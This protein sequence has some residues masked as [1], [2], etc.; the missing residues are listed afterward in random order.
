MKKTRNKLLSWLLVLA[1]LMTMLPTVVL[2]LS[3]DVYIGGVNL[4]DGSKV[5]YYVNGAATAV[6]QEPE[7]WNA[8]LETVGGVATLTIR[9][10]F[11]AASG[12]EGIKS[13]LPLNLVLEG[14]NSVTGGDEDSSWPAYG[15][16]VNGD[17]TISGDGSLSVI[18]VASAED[19]SYGIYAYGQIEINGGTVSAVGGTASGSSYGIYSFSGYGIV[20]NDGTVNATGGTATE[21]SYGICA[22]SRLWIYGGVVNATG[23]T[24]G[25]AEGN[26]SCGIS[27]WEGALISGG[28]VNATGGAAYLSYGIE[29]CYE[30][31]GGTV[32]ATGGDA[33]IYSFG[34]TRGTSST[35]FTGGVVVMRG[36]TV[37]DPSGSANA[38]GYDSIELD[39][40]KIAGQMVGSNFAGSTEDYNEDATAVVL[41][42]DDYTVRNTPLTGTNQTEYTIDTNTAVV[43]PGTSENGSPLIITSSDS[44]VTLNSNLVLINLLG[45]FVAPALGINGDVTVGGSGVLTAIGAVT[46]NN[47]SYG[48][49]GNYSLS[50]ASAQIV[51]IGGVSAKYSYGIGA[52]T[53]VTVSGDSSVVAIGGAMMNDD[54]DSY[55]IGSYG[56]SVSDTSEI[57]AIGGDVGNSAFSYGISTYGATVSGTAKVTAVGGNGGSM[58]ASYGV[59]CP[60][61]ADV[62]VTVSGGTLNAVAGKTGGNSYGINNTAGTITVGNS[63]TGGTVNAVGGPAASFSAG[64][65]GGTV[66]VRRGSLNAVGGFTDYVGYGIRLSTALNVSGGTVNAAGMD[67]GI[68]GQYGQGVTISGGDV[69]AVG[70]NSFGL[71]ASSV[72]SLAAGSFTGGMKAVYC[73]DGVSSLL[74]NG[75]GYFAGDELLEVGDADT[76]GNPGQTV[77]VKS[78]VRE[79]TV[80]FNANGGSGTMNNQ[81]IDFGV[82]TVLSQNSFTKTDYIFTGWNTKADGSGTSYTDKATVTGIANAGESITLYAMWGEKV[83]FEVSDTKHIYQS[84]KGQSITLTP[85]SISGVLTADD[86][87]V[88]YYK[89][90]ENENKLVS[91]AAVTNA[92]ETGKYL[93]VI[94][95]TTGT[96]YSNYAIEK[97]FTVSDTTLPDISE[98]SNIGYMY[99]KTGITGQQ[100][101][102]FFKDGTVN[103]KVGGEF[104][105]ELTNDNGTTP[106]FTS[107]NE[108]VA[109]VDSTGKVTAI[110]KGTATI[111]A[112]SE[113]DETTP[114]YASYTVNVGFATKTLTAND[115]TVTA[116]NKTY[117]GTKDVVISATVKSEALYAGDNIRVDITGEF[118][119]GN[120]GENKTVNYKITGIS[121]T[122]AENYVL[123][124]GII[125][126]TTT[127]SITKA[128]VTIICATATTRIFDGTP[129]SVDVSAMANGAVFDSSNYTVKYNGGEAPSAVGSYLVTVE[130]TA[131]AEQNYTVTQPNAILVIG[132][133]SQEV[134]SVEGVPEAVYYGDNFTLSTEGASGTV[135]YAITSGTEFAEINGADVTVTGVGKVTI[136]ATSVKNGYAD[137]IAT[138]SFNAKQRILIPTATA[139]DK[140]Y[141]GTNGV[142]VAIS[143]KNIVDSDDIT[144]TA[145]GS[146]INADAGND[147]L[148]YVSGIT[149]DGDKKDFYTLDTTSIQTTVDIS[150]KEITG[151][152]IS[153]DSRKYDT[154]SNA[155]ATVTGISGVLEADKGQVEVIG[156]AAFDDENSGTGKT[157]TFTANGL[158]GAKAA[159]YTLT[160]TTA[161]ATADITPLS[162]DFVVGNTAFV[163]DGNDKA[164][165][166]SATDENGKIFKD[167]E[168]TYN[169]TPNA[170]GTYTAT[171]VLNDT[172]NYTTE[173]DDVSVTIS[174]AAQ[175]NLVI[176]G[177]PG[178]IQYGDSFT[179]EAVGGADGGA[180]EWNVDNADVTLSTN[181]E[182]ETTVTIGDVVGEKV[183]IEVVKKTDNYEDISAKV[184]FVPTAKAVTFDISNLEQ[185]YGN[186]SDVEVTPSDTKVSEDDYTIT[187]NGGELPENAGTYTV[188][189]AANGNYSGMQTATLT[190]K[191]ATATGTITG[192]NDSYTYGDIIT[193]VGVTDLK[194]STAAK[195]TYAGTGIYV[196]Q[197]EAPTK[198]GNYTVIAEIT[199]D[200][201]ETLT[202][203]ENFV[204]E[205]KELTVKA[206]DETRAYGE[207]NPIFT[208]SYTGFVNGETKDVLLAEPIAT[209]TANA[210]SGVGEYDITVSGGS[211]ENYK[212]SYDNTGKLTV[213]GATGGSLYITGSTNTAYVNDIFVL[214]AFY[215]NSK[216]NVTWESSDSTIAEIAESGTVT[217]KKAGTVTIKATA[218][219]NYGNAT[220]TFELTVKQT[221]ITLVPTD[222]VKIYTGER[223][224]ITFAH[225]A[226]F[227]PVLSG[228]DK[229]VDVTYTLISNPSVTEPI[230]AGTYSVVYTISDGRYT[231][232]GNTTMYIN[233]AEI[234]VKPKNITKVYGDEPVY[235]LE[236]EST[237]I[238]ANEL[239]TLAENTTFT[240]EGESKIAAVKD[241]G[242][243]IT[244]TLNTTENENLKF[245][246]N[247]TGT[248]TVAKA[249]LTVKVKDITREYG[250]ENPTLEAEY[251]GFKNEETEKTENIFTGNLTL[252]YDASINA[253]TAVGEYADK[254]TAAGIEAANYGITFV[255]GNVKITKIGVIASAGTS[256]SSYLTVKFDKAIA[257]LGV[258]N[259]DVKNG[260]ET[261][262]ITEVTA[263]SDNKT[264]TLKGSF[265]TSVTYTV[266]PN[267]TGST[268]E[269]THEITSEPLSIKPSS[270]GGGGGGGG[271]SAPTTYTVKFETDGGSEIDSVK[272]TKNKTIDEP[273]APTKDD[274]TFDGWYTDEALTEKYDFDSKVT[275]N[276]TLYAKWDKHD[277]EQPGTDTHNC[278][279][280]AFDD[281]DITK[282]YHFDTD[283]VIENG[284]FKGTT[285]TTFEPDSAQTRAMM[286]TV[287]YRAEGEPAVNRSIPFADVDKGAYYA[288]AVIWGQQNGIIKG[289][290]E[291]EFGPDDKITRE[292]IAAI[293][294]R[295]AQYKGYDVS[296]GENTNIL[297][298]DDF[299]SISEYAIPSMQWAVG[300]GLIKGKSE[301]T[302]NPLDNATRAEIAAIL[303]RFIEAN[304]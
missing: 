30:I 84:D 229:N 299:D 240:S 242:Y 174:N 97:K 52:N 296:V 146:M 201:Y 92:V 144:A 61:T 187:Y 79:Y 200:N 220:A 120:A 143:L 205:K 67:Y 161:T 257:G 80:A 4:G 255:P 145:T 156:K 119:D 232:G 231:G 237:L 169:E 285:E 197:S 71:I 159:N 22:W 21:N 298:Y 44:T 56:L 20:I 164:I 125:E 185:T 60:N 89:V 139:M 136:T 48:I 116:K 127:A 26:V 23:G 196:P 62:P 226:D 108:A 94:D 110:G 51:A 113:K 186:I 271:S 175:D 209:V 112:K 66:K 214:H 303:H 14:A 149:L 179:L 104:T 33:V 234:E 248:L 288:N 132:S 163:Y 98:Y 160:A 218:D 99:I 75:Y 294:H 272:V 39:E 3:S 180:Y 128:T 7:V 184:V 131:E 140:E 57:V 83:T 239:T 37:S 253:D 292:Q 12:E 247:G 68:D 147:K 217:A 64:I 286:V 50:A 10:L 258:T 15:I 78:A 208:L 114:V 11:V 268:S 129:Q 35:Q 250:A 53:K 267:L 76:V 206:D 213:T 2:A 222:L 123:E 45:E 279:S 43:T 195:I 54:A 87:D 151:F 28:V 111:T 150:K 215:G 262:T 32:V 223:Q 118:A 221:A 224:D 276:L 73:Q 115:F 133:A 55:G 293:M 6:T 172:T 41:V 192:I 34:I 46:S 193:G 162:V 168:I 82:P 280:L 202:I 243:E 273:A 47:W 38:Y 281:L 70:V 177:L 122:G 225:N 233:K 138:K 251:I 101:P 117:D 13:Y 171:V 77:T 183:E 29:I 130:L 235:E 154:T 106:T 86:F 148:V 282:W 278:P 191:K 59:G 141:D 266:T 283:Y 230:Q 8:K 241:G 204:I 249:P 166:V 36:G 91:V 105:N 199:G 9:N 96:D 178:T 40:M 5:T 228:E 1:M 203:T 24:A 65:Y 219:A 153:A 244:A 170:A 300:S 210:S 16:Y 212:F 100:T 190:I 31:S 207:A 269:A 152:E 167:F 252:A 142:E 137:R 121:G 109:K 19:D 289:Y 165:T 135:T 198:V 126:S 188:K 270:S 103:L 81:I 58:S 291:T 102:I 290:S 304:K 301:S 88:K 42:P 173:Q 18:G 259:F 256:R 49:S 245:V 274:Y 74:A 93:Y 155:A 72:S 295:Y 124:N 176:V 236:T 107:S 277:D 260:E 275:K 158:S 63:S 264:Y 246:V 194:T 85:H 134:F 287:L 284:I 211:A 157:V 90:D 227:T 265:S 263:S 95:F 261:I 27:T 216:V 302:L 182:A 189:V 181:N 254:T 238:S 25:S 297:S 17:L 69:T